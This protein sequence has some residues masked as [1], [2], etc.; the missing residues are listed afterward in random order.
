MRSLALT[1]AQLSSFVITIISIIFAVNLKPIARI[2]IK[3]AL[4]CIHFICFALKLIMCKAFALDLRLICAQL[5]NPK[6]MSW[7]DTHLCSL[8]KNFALLCAHLR[9]YALKSWARKSAKT[10]AHCNSLFLILLPLI[11]IFALTTAYFHSLPLICA[12][13]ALIAAYLRSLPLICANFALTTAYLRWF[14]WHFLF[15]KVTFAQTSAS[16]LNSAPLGA[17]RAQRDKALVR[18]KVTLPLQWI[19]YHHTKSTNTFRL[20][21]ACLKCDLVWLVSI[22]CMQYKPMRA[23]DN[24][25]MKIRAKIM[26]FDNSV[27][28][29]EIKYF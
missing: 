2:F 13:F 16:R 10:C 21:G 25:E 7:W 8:E 28:R 5:K 14:D 12:D 26:I 1:C 11:W 3:F 9:L 20:N 22:V 18:A 17:G 19:I 15:Y 27:T 4:S 23:A 29:N 6:N 24:D